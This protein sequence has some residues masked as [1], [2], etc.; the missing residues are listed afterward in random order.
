MK[1]TVE[2]ER[3]AYGAD[4]IG[5]LPDG[6]A[7][8][9]E[10]GAPG[11]VA[12]VEIVE[13]KGSFARATIAGL[14]EPSPQRVQPESPID[15]VC[16]T[17]PWQHL[18]YD[19]QLSAKRNNVVGALVHTA[20]FD[21]ERAQAVVAAC[22][23]SKRAWNYRNKLELG[24]GTDKDG[25][26]VLGFYRE[27]T[28][29][30]VPAESSHLAHKQIE[31][32][33]K[34]LQGAIRY[35]QGNQ[36]LGIFR[37]GVRH[38]LATGELEVALWTKPGSFPRGLFAKTLSTACKTT[39]VVR[40]L[41]DPGKARK[42][43]GVEILDGRGYW[44]E[45]IGDVEF[46]TQAPSFFQ[47]N[48]AQAG[49]LVELVMQGLGDLEGAY[50]ADLYAGGGTFSVPLALAG[51]DVIAV[52]AAGSSVRDLRFNAENN[53]ADLDVVGGDAARELAD[54]GELDALVV[55]PP[56]A[57]LAESVIGDIAEARPQRV[58]YVSCD[59]V[60]WARDIARFEQSG[61]AL[62]SATPVDMFP[63]TYHVETVSFL[64]PR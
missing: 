58:A 41:A 61:Y 5:H 7:V 37:V 38:S 25:R 55:D 22:V 13:D 29:E 40:V 23:G 18:A 59:P 51:A 62:A 3:M 17:A 32:A 36:D 12:E 24:T 30:L 49:K 20:H 53:G 19:A 52:E 26:F 39:S 10:G 9:V 11:D 50:V 57:G 54:L 1:H 60:T 63:Q 35:A 33:P 56:R 45:R 6:K 8:F 43:K 42:I 34:A 31:R 2:I 4:A 21:E 46:S 64:E 47:V 28:N 27:G 14:A 15:Q 16:G 48:T 44:R